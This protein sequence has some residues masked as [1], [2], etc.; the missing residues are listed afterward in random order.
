MSRYAFL[1]GLPRSGSTLLAS[2]LNQ[3]PDVYVSTNSPVAQLMWETEKLVTRTQQYR[4]NPNP[5]AAFDL[6]AGI[7]PTYHKGRSEQLVI[8][9]CRA[10]GTPGNLRMLRTYVGGEIR[11]VCLVRPVIEV[12]ASFISLVH[13][14]PAGSILDQMLPESFRPV[15]DVRC[16]ALMAPGGDIDRAL[17]TVHNLSQP[18][19]A[20]VGRIISYAD[21]TTDTSAT[22]GEIE[23]FLGIDGYDYDLDNIVNSEPEDDS[24]YGL[25]GMHAVRQSISA[26]TTHPEDIL[27]DYVLNKYGHL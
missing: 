20:G 22:L 27:S 21:L 1:A 5:T 12:L 23:T 18:D 14:S 7:L 6:V 10:W 24:V 17:W 25:A 4:A 3:R 15:D 8:D 16:D 9:K 19:N 11:I 13:R 2:L 26:S